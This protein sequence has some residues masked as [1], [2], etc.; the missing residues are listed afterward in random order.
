MDVFAHWGD[1]G[2]CGRVFWGLKKCCVLHTFRARI[3]QYRCANRIS[4]DSGGMYVCRDTAFA[5]C[6]SRTCCILPHVQ[7]TLSTKTP[8]PRRYPPSE[9]VGASTGSSRRAD[10]FGFHRYQNGQ[11]GNLI[12]TWNLHGWELGVEMEPYVGDSYRGTLRFCM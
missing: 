10:L 7:A 4:I 6:I 3:F 12:Y 8:S 9:A 1:T 2:W 11:S 5:R